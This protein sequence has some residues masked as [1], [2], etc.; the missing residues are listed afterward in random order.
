MEVD[1]VVMRSG[2]DETYDQLVLRSYERVC[3][4]GINRFSPPG[5]RK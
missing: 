1:D 2:D 4:C 3:C 5:Q